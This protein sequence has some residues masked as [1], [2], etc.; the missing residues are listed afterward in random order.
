MEVIRQVESGTSGEIR[1]HVQRASTN[2][3]MNDA[4]KFFRKNRMH[5]TRERNGVLIFI[6]WKS[7]AFAILGD[8]GIHRIVGDV[9]WNETR[10]RMNAHFLKN[11]LKEGIIVGLRSVGEK[12]K[13]AFPPRADDCNELPNTVTEG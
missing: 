9:F 10:D 8:E 5:R 6:S 1:V 13:A 4:K 7:R 12:L 3:V 11:E 2:N